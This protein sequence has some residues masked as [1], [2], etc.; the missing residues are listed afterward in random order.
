MIKPRSVF[1]PPHTVRADWTE[2]LSDPLDFPPSHPS[3]S[4][5]SSCLSSGR[6]Q[7]GWRQALGPL[8]QGRTQTQRQKDRQTHAPPTPPPKKNPNKKPLTRR[9]RQNPPQNA[10]THQPA[11]DAGRPAGQ[12]LHGARLGGNSPLTAAS[13]VACCREWEAASPPLPGSRPHGGTR[14]RRQPA[15]R[16][17]STFSRG[18]FLAA[19]WPQPSPAQPSLASPC[20]A[21]PRRTAPPPPASPGTP[22]CLPLADA[23][24]RC[25][26]RLPAAPG[27]LGGGS[28]STAPPRYLSAAPRGPQ[29]RLGAARR[30]RA[31]SLAPHHLTPPEHTA[32]PLSYLSTSRV[33]RPRG[34][35]GK[36]LPQRSATFLFF[37]L[38][39]A[40]LSFGKL[41]EGRGRGGWVDY[42]RLDVVQHNKA[43]LDPLLALNAQQKGNAGNVIIIILRDGG[44]NNPSYEICSYKIND[45]LHAFI[46]AL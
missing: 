46:S 29:D 15:P 25:D 45:S 5:G 20:R 24:P 36:E 14:R 7:K 6:P 38:Y 21:K 35:R 8:A 16:H 12:P 43:P 44:K 19:R 31:C 34:A 22:P 13:A 27:R 26:A 18:S 42:S 33:T 40:P 10:P 41:P 11:S 3:R 2:H 32:E 39:C 23:S 30:S 4:T 28:P 17:A 1:A 9:D 37:D